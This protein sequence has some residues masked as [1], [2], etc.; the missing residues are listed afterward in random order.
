MEN[1]IATLKDRKISLQALYIA[2]W[3]GTV[4]G[5]QLVKIT[6]LEGTPS[7]KALQSRDNVQSPY[8]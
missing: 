3:P 2:K 5:S 8:C 4:V 6:C 1:A 7:S